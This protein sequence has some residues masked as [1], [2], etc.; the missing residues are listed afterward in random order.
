MKELLLNN[1]EFII[2]FVTIIVTWVLG[3]LAKKSPIINSKRIPLQNILIGF[4]VTLIYYVIT[5]DFSMVVASGS[6]I[7][8]LLYDLVH[9]FNKE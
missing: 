9:N 6:P 5:K 2:S 8:T 4:I 7:A 3:K 1:M